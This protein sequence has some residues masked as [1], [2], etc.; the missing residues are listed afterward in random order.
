MRVKIVC[1]F[2]AAR[3]SAK[4]AIAHF[5]PDDIADYRKPGI[6]ERPPQGTVRQAKFRDQEGWRAFNDERRRVSRAPL[7]SSSC[8][9]QSGGGFCA[10]AETH[11]R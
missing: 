7:P 8:M 10:A 2:R 3:R 5:D 1:P 9:T 6:V 4:I 11:A